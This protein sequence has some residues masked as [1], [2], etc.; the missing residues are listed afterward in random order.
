MKKIFIFFIY[1]TGCLIVQAQ[2]KNMDMDAAPLHRA[3]K[4]LTDVIVHDVFFA[5]FISKFKPPFT[6]SLL[7]FSMSF[8]FNA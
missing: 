8:T 7:V 6:S 3:E 1:I 2:N 5:M 4:A